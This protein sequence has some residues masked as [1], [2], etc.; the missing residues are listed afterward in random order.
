LTRGFTQLS[1][2]MIALAQDRDLPVVYGAVTIGDVW[3]FGQLEVAA[4]QITQD[5][6]LWTV[7]DEL[8]QVV[9]LLVGILQG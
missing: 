9:R 1:A 4:T 7:P 3:R 8:P 6:K 2:E 5:L